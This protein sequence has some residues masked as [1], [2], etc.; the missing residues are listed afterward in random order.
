[1]NLNENLNVMNFSV[2]AINSTKEGTQHKTANGA[3]NN[4]R[5]LENYLIALEN[6]KNEN[7]QIICFQNEDPKINIKAAGKKSFCIAENAIAE[8]INVVVNL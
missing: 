6:I 1:M 3:A 8:S 4:S 7:K 5:T 2:N